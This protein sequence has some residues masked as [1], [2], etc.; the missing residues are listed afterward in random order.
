MATIKLTQTR[1][2]YNELSYKYIDGDTGCGK[3]TWAIEKRIPMFKTSGLSVLLVVPSI[4]LA[5]EIEK[6][7]NS[8]IKAIHSKNRTGE[9]TVLSEIIEIMKT[10]Y[11]TKKPVSIV[12]CEASYLN[13]TT[14]FDVA[15]VKT[16]NWVVIKDE[17]RDPLGITPFRVSHDAKKIIDRFL[18]SFEKSEDSRLLSIPITK[19]PVKLTKE[20]NDILDNANLKNKKTIEILRKLSNSPGMSLA[21]VMDQMDE[22]AQGVLQLTLDDLECD[23]FGKLVQFKM[24]CMNPHVE[25]LVDKEL[26]EDHNILKYSVFQLPS[27]YNMFEQV[28]FMKANFVD[29]FIYHQWMERGVTWQPTTMQFQ[30]MPSH[31]IKIHYLYSD[32]QRWSAS[33]RNSKPKGCSHTIIEEYLD[34]A[35]EMLKDKEFVY[36]LNN[37]YS[38]KYKLPGGT[39][40]PAE[41]H[42][43]NAYSHHTNILLGGSYL[44][45][46][47]DEPFY[48]YYGSS[49]TDSSGLRQTQFYIQQIARTDIRNYNGT[50]DINVYVPTL[51]EA[52]SLL[53]YYKDAELIDENNNR[54]G[55]LNPDFKYQPTNDITPNNDFAVLGKGV[56]GDVIRYDVMNPSPEDI[57]LYGVEF[58]DRVSGNIKNLGHP[59]IR[60]IK[61]IQ[62]KDISSIGLDKK[63]DQEKYNSVKRELPWISAGIY[64][65]DDALTKANCQG[66][67]FI[68]FDFDGS[69]ITDKEIAKV[70]KQ[71]EYLMYTTFSH[72]KND[73]KR[74][75]RIIAPYDRVV[76]IEEH[77]RIKR[78]FINR[79]NDI[80]NPKGTKFKD[81]RDLNIDESKSDAWAKLFVPHKESIITHV[82]RKNGQRTHTIEVDEILAQ[83]PR[84][85]K[86]QPPEIKDIIWT[87][88]LTGKVVVDKNDTDAKRVERIMKVMDT[89]QPHDR[90]QKAVKIGGM[91]K[92]VDKQFHEYIF[93]ELKNRGADKNAVAQARKYANMP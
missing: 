81:R 55:K 20:E 4:D 58:D 12:I 53:V 43:L 45:N 41:C 77:I 75:F 33:F 2:Q 60:F 63:K 74:R 30:K 26:F 71:F 67:K 40:M 48:A 69:D 64:N 29:S 52:L 8:K 34:W 47:S 1:S 10:A 5:N 86:I 66:S 56:H 88:T 44:A 93:D 3:T 78:W 68:G 49:T 36:V 19:N 25:V 21:E 15:R 9:Q 54:V 62:A 79:F 65:D 73:K 31:R 14:F 90:S 38:E 70:M 35:K 91:L 59:H 39:R 6:K 17:P 22:D 87:S 28:Y 76:T 85:P 61:D 7:S 37:E 13:L 42:G 16:D 89:M 84:L 23:I 46:R 83:E 24:H 51:T 57:L 11:D 80:C 92:K 82:T 50:S 27:A 72:D 18:C 32:V